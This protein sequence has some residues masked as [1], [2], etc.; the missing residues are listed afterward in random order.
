M[1]KVRCYAAGE[2][3]IFDLHTKSLII[4]FVSLDDDDDDGN[5]VVVVYL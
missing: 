4:S 5:V 1:M 2:L 3:F